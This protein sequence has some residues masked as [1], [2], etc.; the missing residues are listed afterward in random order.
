MPAINGIFTLRRIRQC[1]IAIL[2]AL[3]PTVA[4]AD[5]VSFS[6]SIT[7]EL[8]EL[9]PTNDRLRVP[10]FDTQGGTR[11][12]DAVTV[13]FG[14]SLSNGGPLSAPNTPPLTNG[15]V[16]NNSANPQTFTITFRTD[17]SSYHGEPSSGAPSAL[18]G[19]DLFPPFTIISQQ[20]YT[21]LPS[22]GSADYNA[23]TA[24]AAGITTNVAADPELAEFVGAGDFGYDLSTRILQS[25]SGGGGNIAFNINTYASANLTVTYDFTVL[26]DTDY[27]DAPDSYGTTS[28]SGGASHLLGGPFLGNCVDSDSGTLSAASFGDPADADDNDDGAAG[29]GTVTGTCATPGDDEDGVTF[30][31]PLIAGTTNSGVRISMPLAASPAGCFVNAWIDFN[32]DGDF[33]DAGEQ[34]TTNQSLTPNASLLPLDNFLVAETGPATPYSTY[35]R[36][37]CYD[38]E[39]VSPS[40]TGNVVNGE[41]EDYLVTIESPPSGLP[42]DYGDAPD[43]AAGTA[44]QNYNTTQGDNGPSH[45]IGNTFLGAC[46]DSDDGTLQNSSATADDTAA[47]SAT[48]SCAGG[49]EDGVTIPALVVGESADSIQIS[50]PAAASAGTCFITAWIDFNNDGDFAD[51][52]EEIVRNEPFAAASGTS[53]LPAFSVPDAGVPLPYTTYARFRCYE[54]LQAAPVATGNVSNGEVEDYL[55][56][57]NSDTPPPPPPTASVPGPIGFALIPL[58]LG[59]A[60]AGG[61]KLDDAGSQDVKC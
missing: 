52:G 6:D 38:A 9:E 55:V 32:A 33:N 54:S 47:G 59:L 16:T 39:Q 11:R 36:F 35:A 1:E 26:D 25:I 42:R 23:S 10:R 51:S 8:T 7:L 53:S 41:V 22:G 49:D 40:P 18:I 57:I 28:A 56:Q 50:M 12:L 29:N 46:V 30:T 4:F 34:I 61:R 21:N 60:W 5:Q 20:S 31:T 13:Q 37:R 58:V 19:S 15:T 3:L 2:L 48:G 24:N 17:A 45:T 44:Q 14:G 27:G 43:D